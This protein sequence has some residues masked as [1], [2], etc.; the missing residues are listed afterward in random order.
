MLLK[1]ICEHPKTKNHYLSTCPFNISCQRF[2]FNCLAP[3]FPLTCVA[4]AAAQPHTPHSLERTLS[5]TLPKHC[6]SIR[7]SHLKNIDRDY[8]AKKV[9]S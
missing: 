9:K 7:Y 8:V 5:G 1:V 4:S 6:C 2:W 3:A